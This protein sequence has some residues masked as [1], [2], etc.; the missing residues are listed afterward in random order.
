M[1]LQIEDFKLFPH[2]KTISGPQVIPDASG[3]YAWY[4]NFSKFQNI[5]TKDDFEKN[6]KLID[7]LIS[8]DNLTGSV[9]SFF[10]RYDVE[11]SEKRLFIEKFITTS[12]KGTLTVGEK[13]AGL[14]LQQCK[15]LFDYLSRFSMLVS[16]LYV[17]IATSLQSRYKQHRKAFYDIKKMQSDGEDELLIFE[18]AEKSFGGRAVLKG[19]NWDY[20]IFAC[21]E[22]PVDRHIIQ[23]QEF[24]LNR[25]YNPVLGRK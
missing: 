10:R 25:F 23:E 12:D 3:M 22:M 5:S 2:E 18:K 20:L 4:L 13:L 11:L 8:K 19:F 16:P 1:I 7:E 14:T 15:D 24:L 6:I 9:K 17:G 21:V